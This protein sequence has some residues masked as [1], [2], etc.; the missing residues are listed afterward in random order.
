MKKAILRNIAI[1]SAIFIVSF[2]IMLITNHFQ[3]RNATPLQTEIME[4]LKEINRQEAA[5]PVLQQQIRQLDLMARQAYFGQLHSLATGVYILLGMLAVFIFCTRSY[6]AGYKSIPDKE[7]DPIDE[8]AIKTKARKYVIGSVASLAAVALV[9]VVL[10]MPHLRAQQTAEENLHSEITAAVQDYQGTEEVAFEAAIATNE[11]ETA[12]TPDSNAEMTAATDDAPAATQAETPRVTHNAFR[13]NNGTGISAARGLPTRWDLSAGTN[14]AWRTEIS[15]P[16]MSSPVINNNRVFITGAD[17][18]ARELFC[19]DLNTG[20]LLWRLAAPGELTIN[21]GDLYFSQMLAAST[22]TTNGN[23]VIAAFATGDVI[24]A[25]MDGNMLWSS[26]LGVPDNHYGFASSPLIFGNIVIIQFDDHANSRVLALDINTGEQ[27]WSTSRAG[28][29][30]L[31]WS[32]PTI[33]FVDNTPQLVLIGQPYVTAYNPNNGAVLWQVRGMSAEPG[34]SAAAAGGVIFAAAEHARMLAINGADGEILWESRDYLPSI[35]SPVA[36]RDNV[37]LATEYGVVA[38]FCAQTGSLRVEHDFPTGFYSSLM[39]AEGRIF[40][41]DTNGVMHVF[42]ADD[43]FTL[44][45]SFETGERTYATPAFTDGRI[46]VRTE[47]SIYKVMA[48]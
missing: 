9:F 2:S 1:V 3:V 32:S 23:L 26:H 25:D 28:E 4:T 22:P 48:N 21:I 44:L 12:A 39:I 5:N 24:A 18:Q 35:S 40:L 10:T 30:G 11:T 16:G 15:R 14:I 8:W 29:R 27:R 34:A 31:T 38:S 6:F 43:N 37:F 47:N 42:T 19:Y 41:F 20:E 33:A 36:T 46:V 7:I 13:G 17:A 45:H